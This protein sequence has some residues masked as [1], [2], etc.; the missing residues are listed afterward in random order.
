VSVAISPIFCSPLAS[1]DAAKHHAEAALEAE[2]ES[3]ER[4][5]E[6]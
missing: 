6:A 5:H 2:T 1:F 4:G 3:G